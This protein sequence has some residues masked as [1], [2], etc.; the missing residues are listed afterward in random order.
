MKRGE[1]LRHLRKAGCYLKREGRS[2]SLWL[3]PRTGGVEAV[4]RHTEIPDKLVKKICR[5]LSVPVIGVS[6]KSVDSLVRVH[7]LGEG[8]STNP[9]IQVSLDKLCLAQDNFQRSAQMVPGMRHD[10]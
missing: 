3:N 1:L 10:A 2:H 7:P 5:G 4:P 9:R 8:L 6:P